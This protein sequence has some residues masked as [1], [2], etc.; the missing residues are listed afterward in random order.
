MY[1]NMHSLTL[2]PCTDGF[3]IVTENLHH[4][5]HQV[6]GVEEEA[7]VG[8]V[9]L[10]GAA[11]EAAVH[12][13]VSFLGHNGFQFLH[14]LVVHTH[15]TAADTDIVLFQI[16]HEGLGIFL[17]A[18]DGLVDKYGDAALQVGLGI[19]VV[20]VAVTGSND[21]AVHLAHELVVG[22]SNRNT[23]QLIELGSSLRLMAVNACKFDVWH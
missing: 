10:N 22:L 9:H 5:L 21:D 16:L 11:K 13:A 19:L 7:A 20:V 2:L 12:F 18:S 17:A 1:I 14:K 3:G 6:L 15:R 23:E 4:D 8:V